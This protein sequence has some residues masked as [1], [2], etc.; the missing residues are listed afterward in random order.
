MTTAIAERQEQAAPVAAGDNMVAMIERLARSPDVDVGK[1]EKL[2]E[3]QERIMA[4]QASAAYSAALADMQTELPA[5]EKRGRIKIKSGDPGQPYALWDDINETIKPI[6]KKHGFSLS[7]RTGTTEEGKIT[8]TAILRHREGHQEE[9]TVTLPHDSSGSKNAVQ[10]VGSSTQYGK[11]YAAGALLNLT[12]KGEDDD[13]NAGGAKNITDEQASTLY[14]K[15]EEARADLGKFIAHFGV[16]AVEDLPASAY[17]KAYRMLTQKA[18]R[19]DKPK[20]PAKDGE[21]L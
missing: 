19:A 14:D 15:I 9:T 2:L 7:F 3:M 13:G 16:A 18:A 6:L 11:R 17:D 12:F 8:T 20:E 10:A 4:R 1:L 5:I 21:L